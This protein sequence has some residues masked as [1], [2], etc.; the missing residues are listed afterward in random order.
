[1]PD[2]SP[3]GAGRARVAPNRELAGF[4][5]KWSDRPLQG[6]VA[7]V[8][9]CGVSCRILAVVALLTAAVLGPVELLSA[10]AAG[11]GASGPARLDGVAAS[12][13]PAGTAAG[14]PLEGVAASLP[15]PPQPTAEGAAVI[16]NRFVPV[17]PNRVL[18]TRISHGTTWPGRLP[19]N[20]EIA[21]QIAGVADVPGDAG[22]VVLNLTVTEPDG[23][24]FVTAYPAG[25]P[26]PNAS[27]VNVERAGQT[28]ANLVTV[29]LGAG[30]VGLYNQMP[31]HLVADVFGYYV[32]AESATA[33][34]FQASA[35]T[36]LLDTRSSGMLQAG[37]PVQLAVAGTAGVPATA[38]AAV[39][40]LTA[41]EPAAAGYVSIT[42]SA[43][44]AGGVS[45]LNV[46]YAGQTIAN[47]VI[48]PLNAGSVTIYPAITTHVIV[49]VDGW[50]TGSDSGS[51]SDGLFVPVTPSR[52]LDTRT[53]HAPS[54]WNTVKPGINASVD[55]NPSSQLGA[56]SPYSAVV[57]NATA[58]EATAAG[59]FTLFGAGLGQPL[60]SNLNANWPGQTVPN[61]AI[62]PVSTAGFTFFTSSGASLIVDIAG[63]FTGTSPSPTNPYGPNG[64]TG[65][66]S[67]GPHTFLYKVN[68]SDV[69]ARWD[70]CAV[71]PF[72]VNLSGAPAFALSELTKAVD[73]VKA[74]T[75][76]DLR[77]LGTTNE[78]ATGTPPADSRA[79]IAFVNGSENPRINGVAGLGGGS[80][81]Q[82][83][84]SRPAYVTRGYVLI[85]ESLAYTQGT[86][87]SGLEGLLLHEIGH[88]VGLN[89]V[90]S[91]YEVMY[92]TM[93]DLPHG[94]FGPGDREGLYYMGAAQGC[95]ASAGSGYA[96]QSLGQD[97]SPVTVEQQADRASGPADDADRRLITVA[98][99]L[100]QGDSAAVTTAA[101]SAGVAMAIP[102]SL[103]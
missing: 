47:Q 7:D 103:R 58:T 27:S 11:P 86:G 49:D 29:P 85:N 22:A 99:H 59:F 17:T 67:F 54:P 37:Q 40:N 95:I 69:P 5:A 38:T 73:K 62:V 42:P 82:A 44:Q 92:G 26:L 30:S 9:H 28:V 21:V 100:D 80:F 87:S 20:G 79:V 33:G 13:V 4:T 10:D 3:A 89:H 78:G 39:L 66:P 2:V 76:L 18:D 43:E 48:V 70:P 23:P 53:G 34:R 1:M 15:S 55:V 8:D 81:Y 72:R 68:E 14:A 102:D 83:T 93:H 52:V 46:D 90:G 45:N 24:G 75:G 97:P 19:T 6:P 63:Y 12:S 91:T 16:T 36:R 71:I 64:L 32:P 84:A 98:C 51:G 25:Q 50:Y 56:P 77:Y 101:A 65:P 41:T 61:H 96:N 94:G 31:T 60:A 74:A 88:M 35:P 57:V